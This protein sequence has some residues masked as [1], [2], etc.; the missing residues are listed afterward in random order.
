MRKMLPALALLPFALFAGQALA[1]QCEHSAPRNLQLDLRGVKA[2]QFDIGPHELNVAASP[3]A[4]AAVSGRACAS[5]A[6]RLEALTL[7]QQRIGDKLIVTAERRDTLNFS[8]GNQ[9]AYLDLHATVPDN[10][11][12]QL[13]VGSG[14]A[15][16]TGASALSLD[17]G[18]GDVKARNIR[19][20]VTADLNSGDIELD[21]IG[22]LQILS[23]GSGDLDARRVARGVTIGSIGSGDVDVRDVGGDVTAERIGSGDLDVNDVRGNLQVDRVGSGSVGHSGIVGRTSVPQDD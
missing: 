7:T 6:G 20:L 2:V 3:N 23:V 15:I 4:K 1:D 17:V 11:M 10:V 13:K 9:Y 22:S 19:G 16:V 12:V 14:D 18:S 8:W 21:T 5:D